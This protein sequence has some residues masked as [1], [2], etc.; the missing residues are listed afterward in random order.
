MYYVQTI[1]YRFGLELLARP[2][3]QMRRDSAYGT[4][5]RIC[6]ENPHQIIQTE[7]VYLIGSDLS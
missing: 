5:S 4:A 3:E 7:A 2:Q 6:D 1:R